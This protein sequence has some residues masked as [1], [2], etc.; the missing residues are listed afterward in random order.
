[1]KH[2]AAQ[3]ITEVATRAQYG[4]SAIATIFSFINQYAAAIG[5]V[6]AILGFCVNWYYKHKQ[7]KREEKRMGNEH[8]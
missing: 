8:P 4:G 5:V 7:D 3:T 2:E 1:M 6:I